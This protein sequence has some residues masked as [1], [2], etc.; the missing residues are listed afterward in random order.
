MSHDSISVLKVRDVLMVTMPSDPDDA[1]IALLQERTLEA[2][3]QTDAN[4][5]I[6]D[7]SRVE[8]LDSYFARTVAET[9]Q[10]VNLM[11]GETV[12]AGMRPA[13]AITATQLGLSL[14]RTRTALTVELAL[15]MT[16]KD[17]SRTAAGGNAR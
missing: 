1:T 13:V 9:A 11:G 15:D 6:L 7:L 8:T 14:G 4:R 3:E 2:M 17:A 16:R 5:L 10:M 12:I